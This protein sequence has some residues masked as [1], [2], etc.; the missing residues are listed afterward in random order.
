L[1]C[2]ERRPPPARYLTWIAHDVDTARAI[3]RVFD[4]LLAAPPL[5]PLYLCASLVLAEAELLLSKA[6]AAQEDLAEVYG[7]LKGAPCRAPRRRPDPADAAQA[8][9]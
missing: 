3:E 6:G 2:S 8:S 1:R 4:Y 5:A 9:S 7:A